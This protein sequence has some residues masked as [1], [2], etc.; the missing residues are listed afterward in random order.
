MERLETSSLC[1]MLERHP[2]IIG[3][4]LLSKAAGI[5]RRCSCSPPKHITLS[6]MIAFLAIY[7]P[8][9]PLFI[10]SNKFTPLHWG[11]SKVLLG[12]EASH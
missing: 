5:P 12:N 4:G 9:H 2:V 10:G 6:C 8:I 3:A 7:V 1:V 11:L